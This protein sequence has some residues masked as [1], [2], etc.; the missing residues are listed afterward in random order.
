MI[1]SQTRSMYH[2]H[3]KRWNQYFTTDHLHVVD[4]DTFIKEP[5]TELQNIETFLNITPT[6]TDRNFFFN[7]TKGFYCGRDIREKGV[8]SCTKNK[9]LSKAKGRK[10]PPVKPGTFDKLTEFFKPHNAKLY[11]MMNRTFIWPI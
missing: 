5:W 10:K 3:M 1:G 11:E 8:W 4:G 7:A 2:T 9:C 6:I